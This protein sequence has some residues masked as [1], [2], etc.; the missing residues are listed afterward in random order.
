MIHV[1]DPVTGKAYSFLTTEMTLPPGLIALL[2]KLRWDVE[3][4]FDEAKNKLEQQQAWG[5][6]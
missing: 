2:Y 1:Y 3:K 5:Q 4:V 6:K